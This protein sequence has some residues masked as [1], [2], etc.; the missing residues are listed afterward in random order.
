LYKIK[1]T[2]LRKANSLLNL[3]KRYTR[4]K[5]VITEFNLSKYRW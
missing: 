3:N 1:A 4:Y 5:L 2:A